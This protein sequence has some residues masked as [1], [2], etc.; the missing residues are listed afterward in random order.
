MGS[1]IGAVVM[2]VAVAVISFT[3]G[4]AVATETKD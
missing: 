4:A 2:L 1:F 3:I